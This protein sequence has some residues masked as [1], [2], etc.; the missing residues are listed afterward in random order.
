[1]G[2]VKS[3]NLKPGTRIAGYRIV[4]PLGRGWEG[5]V[6]SA[7]EVP[8]DAARAIKIIARENLDSVRQV[9]STA[10]FFEQLASTR[11]VARYFHMGQWFLDDNEGLFF[12]VFEH[13]EGPTL[14]DFLAEGRR[15]GTHNELDAINLVRRVAAAIARVHEVG[16]AVGDFEDGSNIIISGPPHDRRPIFCDLDPGEPDRPNVDFRSDAKEMVTLADRVFETLQPSAE[17]TRVRKILQ[18]AARKPRSQ[19]TFAALLN[20]LAPG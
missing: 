4:K 8:T 12:L 9:I 1:M 6:Y 18:E 2:K 10:W 13:L 14:A 7:V 16:Y 3:L 19:R 20:D 5:E 15:R 17:L 11:S